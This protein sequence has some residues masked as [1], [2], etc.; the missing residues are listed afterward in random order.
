MTYLYALVIMVFRTSRLIC[1]T[2]NLFAINQAVPW[3]HFLLH[4]KTHNPQIVLIRIA[5]DQKLISANAHRTNHLFAGPLNPRKVHVFMFSHNIKFRTAQS[6]THHIIIIKT[7]NL[8]YVSHS[9]AKYMVR[10]SKLSR[11]KKISQLILLVRLRPKPNAAS[12]LVAPKFVVLNF[13]CASWKQSPVSSCSSYMTL[14]FIIFFRT[15]H[16]SFS[17]ICSPWRR[18]Q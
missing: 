1:S 4:R 3:Y 15:A 9:A 16:S 10:W 14:P 12:M 18:L 11:K 5:N 6:H 2:E 8:A 17:G 7:S 13:E